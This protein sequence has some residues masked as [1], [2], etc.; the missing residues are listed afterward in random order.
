MSK[1]VVISALGNPE[2][3]HPPLSMG[4]TCGHLLTHRPWVRQGPV[5]G[6][7]VGSMPEAGASPVPLQWAGVGTGRQQQAHAP[8]CTRRCGVGTRVLGCGSDP[9]APSAGQLGLAVSQPRSLPTPWAG[10]TVSAARTAGS[11]FADVSEEAP[12]PGRVY[13]LPIPSGQQPLAH[14]AGV[15]ILGPGG[16]DRGD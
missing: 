4:H 11:G 3:P 2:C 10:R 7:D 1:D 12:G 9:A 14:Q 15:S 16:R 6:R 13:R 5:S 8:S